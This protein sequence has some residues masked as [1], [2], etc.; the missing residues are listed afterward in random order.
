VHRRHLER[1][2]P[3]IARGR[4][5]RLSNALDATAALIP[6]G[7]PLSR[8]FPANTHPFR[9]SSH[10]LYFVGLPLAE[11]V[12]LIHEG[13]LRLF[14]KEP[15]PDAA[16]WHGEA[17][18]IA[19][20][21]DALGEEV[22]PLDALPDALRG[23]VV[24]SIPAPDASTRSEQR[25]WLGRG[26]GAA[27]PEDERLRAAIIELRL[28]H[29]AAAIV[30][31]RRA[32]DV[33]VMAHLRGMAATRPGATEA[34]VCAAMEAEIACRGMCTAYGSIVSVHGEVL[35]NPYRMERLATGDLLLADVGAETEGGF[36]GD[37]TRT[38]PVGG[39]YSATQRAVYDVVLGAQ[40]AALA[41]VRPG[42]RFRDVHLAASRALTTGLVE[43][44]ILR[45][46]PDE[47]VADRV[48]ALFFP[49]GVGHLLGLDVH[50][51]EDLGDA[52]GYPTG[53]T[54]SAEAGLR[55]LRLDRDLLPGMAVTIEPGFYQVPALLSPESALRVRAGDRL[56][57]DV[58]A[59]FADVRGI[60][61]EDDVLVTDAGAERLTEAL[62]RAAMEIESLVGTTG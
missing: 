18:S 31:L 15:S 54:R 25:E 30:E 45:G 44:G 4:R 61:I 33:T 41:S 17:P 58:L 55:H 19:D 36:A 49:H 1:I 56:R 51:M 53:R 42:V 26:A 50:D 52:A 9:A 24:G 3:A 2:D 29:D 10:F 57:E 27:T 62:P 46:D 32:A 16:L 60:R 37:V 38:W 14:V 34:E 8:N 13:K 39:K 48:E 5:I 40:S 21:A 23:L 12:A 35:H 11:A 7:A 22:S 20:I 43:L 28:V 6:A 59:R 47:L